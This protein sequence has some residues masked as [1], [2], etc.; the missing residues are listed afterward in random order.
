MAAAA[1]VE[2]Q[3]V[4]V[5]KGALAAAAEAGLLLAEVFLAAA[6]AALARLQGAAALEWAG[7]FL[8]RMAVN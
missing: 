2:R 1:V 5:E 4:P 6:Q 8:Y 3:E 7:P